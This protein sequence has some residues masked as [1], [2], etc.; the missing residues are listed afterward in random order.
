L[1]TASSLTVIEPI[2]EHGDVA[3]KPTVS[4]VG[5]G[6]VGG[7][8]GLALRDA[9][10]TI[11]AAWSH[12]RAGRQRAHALLG[13]P[14]LEP[15]EVAAAAEIVF[16]TVPDDAI[17]SMAAA[18]APGVR[19]KSLVLHTSGGTSI[20][21]LGPAR[22]AGARI[23][24]LH[25]LQTIPD[26]TSGAA[27]LGGSAVAVT[28]DRADSSA[29]MRLARA[30]GGRPFLLADDAKLLYHAAAVFASNYVVSSVWAATTLLQKAGVR[31]ATDLLA[32]LVRT[33]VEN[34]LTRGGAKAITGPVV[35][36]DVDVVRRH[37][38]A[39]RESD[40]TEGPIT[41]AYRHL[42]RMTIA[43]AHGDIRPI[44]KATA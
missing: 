22:D 16:V 30:W 26:A 33:T 41:D 34:V 10:Y 40:P 5:A 25:P 13:A 37:V 39:L 8:I 9:G 28:C 35:R 1:I 43:L 23:G 6:R 42:A 17:E 7:A 2:K 44:E 31:N 21:A 27:A 12:S 11:T 15:A 24:C 20:E 4:I 3:R 19:A 32:P 14:V 36:G 18:I 29:V 38:H